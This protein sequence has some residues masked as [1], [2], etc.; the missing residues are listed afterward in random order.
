MLFNFFVPDLRLQVI[1]GLLKLDLEILALLLTGRQP[2]LQLPD[3][4]PE[5]CAKKKNNT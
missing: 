4:L 2:V 1:V 3:D 5:L